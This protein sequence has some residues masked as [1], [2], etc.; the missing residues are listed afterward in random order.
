MPESNPKLDIFNVSL[1]QPGVWLVLQPLWL[2]GV[3]S[4]PLIQVLAYRDG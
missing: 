3:T 1:V 4:P 2:R